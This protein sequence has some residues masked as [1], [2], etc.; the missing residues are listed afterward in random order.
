MLVTTHPPRNP[1]HDNEDSELH[2]DE[3][4]DV[5]SATVVPFDGGDPAAQG[6]SRSV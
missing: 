2:E 6:R 3:L 1:V 5:E 4:D